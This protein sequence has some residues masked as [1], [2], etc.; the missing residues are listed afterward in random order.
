MERNAMERAPHPPY[1]PDLA[2]SDFYLFGHVKQRLRG[3]ESA[4]QEV[5]LYA[6]EDVLRGIKK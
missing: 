2:T 3:Y 5:L 6:T 1:S 4:D